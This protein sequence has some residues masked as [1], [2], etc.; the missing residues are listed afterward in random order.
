MLK[1]RWNGRDLNQRPIALTE[2][3]SAMIG[4]EERGAKGESR[5]QKKRKAEEQKA[6]SVK[7]ALRL[8]LLTPGF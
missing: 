4:Q 7:A 3:L 2:N 1:T 8:S 6:E 5:I